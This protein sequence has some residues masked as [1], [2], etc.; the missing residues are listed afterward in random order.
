M[1]IN[2][3]YGFV[4]PKGGGKSYYQHE[5]E[6]RFKS[7]GSAIISADFSDGIRQMI[8]N[9]FGLPSSHIDIDSTYYA[10]WKNTEMNIKLPIDDSLV[11]TKVTGRDLLTNVG[12]SMKT[13]LRKNDIWARYTINDIYRQY[14]DLSADELNRFNILVGSI[15]FKNELQGVLSTANL[16]SEITNVSIIFCNYNNEKYNPNVHSSEK[17][18]HKLIKQGFHHRDDVTNYLKYLIDAK[19]ID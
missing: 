10:A 6:H 16:L 14:L 4:G 19:E 5:M 1:F 3:L 2:N 11:E 17:L 18:A 7:D 12:E 15:R 9:I 8:L 13:L